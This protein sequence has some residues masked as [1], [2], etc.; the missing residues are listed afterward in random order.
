ML[1]FLRSVTGPRLPWAEVLR[2]RFALPGAL[3]LVAAALFIVSYFQPYWHMTL[4]APQYPKGLHVTAHLHQL[5]GDV[6]E[7][8][9]LNHYIGMRPL[10]DAAQLERQ[11]S[12]LLVLCTAGLLLS[13]L[14]LHSRWAGLLALPALA[15]PA[16]FLIDLHLWLSHF[17]QNLDPQA[18]LSSSI[19]PFTPPVLGTGTVGQFKTVA[20]AGTGWWLG[21]RKSME[22]A[23]RSQCTVG[24]PK[25]GG[26]GSSVFARGDSPEAMRSPR[27]G[28]RR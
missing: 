16:G 26:K 11:A 13:G 19:K 22:G 1:R 14:F 9:G 5:S 20:T 4:V 18:P 25:F 27:P 10:N 12:W 28:S 15:F 2:P 23:T 24:I 21:G 17:G 6:A 3:L 7:I 8:D